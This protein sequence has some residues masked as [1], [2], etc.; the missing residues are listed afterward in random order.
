MPLARSGPPRWTLPAILAVFLLLGL[1]Y[2]WQVPPFEGPDEGEHFAYVTWLVEQGSFPPQ[3]AA[4]WETP[5][6]QEAG[7]PPFYYLLASLPARLIDLD[8]PPAPYRINPYAF[9]KG[10]HF[11]FD[12]DNRAL[13]YPGDARPLRG[14]WL[15]LYLARLL[16]LA[17]GALL[18][19]PSG[20]WPESFIRGRRLSGPTLRRSSP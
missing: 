14:G 11:P 19:A 5:V 3:G 16:S 2:I 7:Q 1:V 20:A 8:D 12:N 17:S 4:A 15:A 13:H 18:V 6:R 9:T 10:P